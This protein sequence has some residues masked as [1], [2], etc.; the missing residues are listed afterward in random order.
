MNNS[1]TKK[2]QVELLNLLSQLCD[3]ETDINFAIQCVKS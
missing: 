3:D 1:S 2:E